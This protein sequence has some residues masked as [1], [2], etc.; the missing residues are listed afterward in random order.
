M[1]NI[2]QANNMIC[3]IDSYIL[4][5]NEAVVRYVSN[6]TQKLMSDTGGVE[7]KISIIMT[8]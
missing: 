6:E 2:E 8:K 3:F 4:V 1:D 7:D 5:I